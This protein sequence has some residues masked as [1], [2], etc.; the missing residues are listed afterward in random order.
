MALLEQKSVHVRKK[1]A[2]VITFGIGL[3]LIITMFF[4]YRSQGKEIR[5]T[6]GATTSI[7][8]F[9]ATILHDTQSYFASK[10]AIITK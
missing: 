7:G 5:G 2:L 10:R 8:G 6:D 9:Y 1:I 4:V 3:I